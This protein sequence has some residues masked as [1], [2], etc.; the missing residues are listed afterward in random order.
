MV[1]ALLIAAL[2]STALAIPVPVP[3][4]G[5]TSAG[6]AYIPTTE[7]LGD[8]ALAV[9]AQ[10]DDA[11]IPDATEWTSVDNGDEDGVGDV[12]EPK[13]PVQRRAVDTDDLDTSALD[14][15]ALYTSSLNTGSLTTT[16]PNSTNTKRRSAV[17][18]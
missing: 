16:L 12:S 17:L 1:R 15:S 14:T 2:V 10:A 18:W 3:A 5:P 9:P 13:L 8:P 4:D 11:A 7:E 6:D